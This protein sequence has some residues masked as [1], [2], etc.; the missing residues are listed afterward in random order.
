MFAAD[1]SCM[2]YSIPREQR[3]N[4]SKVWHHN[5]VHDCREKGLRGDDLNVN[6]TIHHTVA[7]NL[8]KGNGTGSNKR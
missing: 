5:W 4:C 2:N 6:L 1:V 8:G 7:F 3:A